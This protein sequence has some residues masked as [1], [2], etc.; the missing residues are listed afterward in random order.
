MQHD[1]DVSRSPRERTGPLAGIRVADFCWMG[2]GSVAH[3]GRLRRRGHQDR[4]PSA[5]G[6][7]A[8]AADRQGCCPLLRRGG[9]EPAL[10][11]GRTLQQLLSQQARHHA[12]HVRSRGAS[13][14]RRSHPALGGRHRELSARRDEALG[15]HLRAP[16]RA[17]APPPVPQLR[18]G[19]AGRVGHDVHGRPARARATIWASP[20]APPS[21]TSSRSPKQLLRGFEPNPDLFPS[22]HLP[23]RIAATQEKYADVIARVAADSA[24]EAHA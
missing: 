11:Q 24:V 9:R 13:P 8:Q 6:H 14:G 19:R 21:C 10:E 2:V 4:E 20:T 12:G 1:D 18:A 17:G 23:Q 16:A 15:A 22:G 5:P 3:A 7:P